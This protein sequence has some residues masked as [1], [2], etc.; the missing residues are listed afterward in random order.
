MLK[1]KKKKSLSREYKGTLMEGIIEKGTV[2][3]ETEDLDRLV[4]QNKF[5]RP[6]GASNFF[7]LKHKHV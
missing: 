7:G 1:K 4:L 3:R 6:V 5:T 2:H